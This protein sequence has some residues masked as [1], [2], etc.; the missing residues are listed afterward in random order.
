MFD[1]D[2]KNIPKGYDR[3]PTGEENG[4]FYEIY[5]EAFARFARWSEDTPVPVLGDASTPI[6]EVDTFYDFWYEFKSWRILTGNPKKEGEDGKPAEE[7][8]YDLEQAEDAYER[9]WMTT[10]NEHERKKLKRGHMKV[11]ST[12]R[13]LAFKRD[14]RVNQARKAEFAVKEAEK[15]AKLAAK[16]AA[17]ALLKAEE[18]KLKSPKELAVEAAAAEKL[19][20]EKKKLDAKKQAKLDEQA[21]AEEQTARIAAALKAR[22]QKN[23]EAKAAPKPAA[24]AK[25]AKKK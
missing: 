6:E 10:Q 1:S 13:D 25:D 24:K 17:A 8:E 18:D 14:P 23:K 11:I 12:L 15:Q 9:R 19:A 21:A 16:E 22:G 4:D 3:I 7:G 5:G 2:P 20:A